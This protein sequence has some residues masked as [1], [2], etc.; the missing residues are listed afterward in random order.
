MFYV[1]LGDGL[2]HLLYVVDSPF[3][4]SIE[5]SILHL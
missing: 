1:K 3:F 2:V 5:K 4:E